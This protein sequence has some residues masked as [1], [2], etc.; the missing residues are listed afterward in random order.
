[1]SAKRSFFNFF[2]FF[3]RC[4]LEVDAEG[5]VELCELEME[6]TSF[7]SSTLHECFLAFFISGCDSEVE[8]E[9]YVRLRELEMKLTPFS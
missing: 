8:A 5:C 3:F 2:A 6:L 4:K 9:G 1:A 7:S